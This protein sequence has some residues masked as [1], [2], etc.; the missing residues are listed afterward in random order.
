MHVHILT[1]HFAARTPRNLG[2]S[3]ATVGRL[4]SRTAAAA[5]DLHSGAGAGGK[6]LD[7]GRLERARVL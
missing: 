4:A 5:L 7:A 2:R 1:H 3:R 6:C